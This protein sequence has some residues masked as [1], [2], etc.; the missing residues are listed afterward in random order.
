MKKPNLKNFK[1]PG[2]GSMKNAPGAKYIKIGL[3]V[4]IAI[5]VGA[6]GLELTNN[7][8]DLGKL[9][10]GQ[11]A[12]EAKVKRAED[13]T[14]LIGKCDPDKQYN[15]ED[16]ETQAEAQEILED[17]GD[18]DV[19]GLDADKDGIACEHLPQTK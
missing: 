1:I 8:W 17:C 16:F 19:H 3:G 6:L 13:G 18:Y 10:S 2:K 5:L 7:D 11:S 12:D 9:L 15:C 4:I 14:I